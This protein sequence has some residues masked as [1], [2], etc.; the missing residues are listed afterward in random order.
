MW[1][2]WNKKSCP[3]PATLLQMLCYTWNLPVHSGLLEWYIIVPFLSFYYSW[4][5]NWRVVCGKMSVW[6]S[7]DRH[8]RRYCRRCRC[9]AANES[10]SL[11]LKWC[12]TCIRTN[13][14]LMVVDF[15]TNTRYVTKSNQSVDC[16]NA[17]I[18]GL[19]IDGTKH[20]K[21]YPWKF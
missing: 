11:G 5:S 14:V 15:W 6:L 9:S 21:T 12:R 4:L 20:L 19:P 7:H 10:S 13:L 17:C 3:S 16:H 8:C 2:V 18:E 1:P